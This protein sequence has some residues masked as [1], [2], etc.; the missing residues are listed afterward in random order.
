M[1]TKFSAEKKWTKIKTFNRKQLKTFHFQDSLPKL[2]LPTLEQTDERVRKAVLPL[3]M[4]LVQFKRFK[5]LFE[6]N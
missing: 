5:Q 2:P 1:K 4:R 3:G 6:L